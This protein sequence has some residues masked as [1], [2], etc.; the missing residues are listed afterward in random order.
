M[1]KFRNTLQRLQSRRV[2]VI[3]RPRVRVRVPVVVYCSCWLLNVP[4]AS[5]Q[6][7]PLQE[8]IGGTSF[9]FVLY[10]EIYF[11]ADVDFDQRTAKLEYSKSNVNT[12]SILFML[13]IKIVLSN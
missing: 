7:S 11:L 10:A 6:L 5:V 1:A 2:D 13:D 8:S 3:V 4:Y 12:A 9:V